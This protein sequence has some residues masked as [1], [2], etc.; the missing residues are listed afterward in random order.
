M[1]LETFPRA[2]PPRIQI[3]EHEPSLNIHHSCLLASSQDVPR[4]LNGGAEKRW[5]GWIIR[6]CEEE[7]GEEER[8]LVVHK[9]TPVKMLPR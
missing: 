1:G 5:V 8:D 9:N 6:K 3:S 2:E 4:T 7:N